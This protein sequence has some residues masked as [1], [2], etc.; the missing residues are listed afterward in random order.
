MTRPGV[1][2]QKKADSEESAFASRCEWWLV[3]GL[4]PRPISEAAAG[5]RQNAGILHFVQNHNEQ[6]RKGH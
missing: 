6:L 1:R 4:K 2:G 5:Q 3:T